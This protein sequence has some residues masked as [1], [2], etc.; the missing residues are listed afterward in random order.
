MRNR[1]PGTRLVE[2]MRRDPRPGRE[3]RAMGRFS[4]DCII[5]ILFADVGVVL[6][7]N[8]SYS[9]YCNLILEEISSQNRAGES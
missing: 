3:A 5:L 1:P 7:L 9:L 4:Y 2:G 6:V 8:A